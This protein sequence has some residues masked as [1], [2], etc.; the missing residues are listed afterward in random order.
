MY[1]DSFSLIFCFTPIDSEVSQTGKRT[2]SLLHLQDRVV[3]LIRLNIYSF[4]LITI[5][6]VG[7]WVGH[8][9][10]VTVFYIFG[11]NDS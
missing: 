8:S 2:G 10:I 6:Q 5:N 11:S 9:K 4:K 7:C 3:K 1:L